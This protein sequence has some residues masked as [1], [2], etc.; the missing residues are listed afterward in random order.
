MLAYFMMPAKS[1]L[2]KV[3]FFHLKGVHKH[4]IINF[5]SVFKN[6]FLG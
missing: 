6:P 5:A 3:G 2:Y 1:Y 4:K